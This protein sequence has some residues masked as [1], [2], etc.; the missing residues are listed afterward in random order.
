MNSFSLRSWVEV[1]K[2]VSETEDHII[3]TNSKLNFN[4]LTGFYFNNPLTVS[5]E[6]DSIWNN[7]TM[8][9]D[10]SEIKLIN[11]G[12]EFVIHIIDFDGPILIK[13][14][15][16][17]LDVFLCLRNPPSYFINKEQACFDFN[18]R[19]FN[20][21]LRRN[22]STHARD[23]WNLR[24]ALYNFSLQVSN[25]CHLVERHFDDHSQLEPTNFSP[26]EEF[27][28]DYLLKI[29][30]SK[31]A[32]VLPPKLPNQFISQLNKSSIETVKLLL[33]NTV[34]VRF[35]PLYIRH[36]EDVE[37]PFPDY[38]PPNEY[39][40][41]P[42]VKVTPS[43]I[44]FMSKQ[45]V[46]KNRVYRYFPKSENFLLVSFTDEYDGNP[47]RS[48]IVNK[49]FF[50]I[51]LDGIQVGGKTFTFLGCSNSQLRI[52]RCWFSCLD[53]QTVYDTIGEFPDDWNAG[54]KL[55]RIALAFASSRNTVHLDHDRYLKNVGPDVLQ[56]KINFSDGIGRASPQL[57]SKIQ[58]IIGVK[59]MVSAFQIRVGGIKGVI[60]LYDEQRDDV[61]FRKSMKKFES[62]HNII[63]VLNFS[64]PTKLYLNRHVI[65][66][67]S[68]NG[69]EN[70][71]LLDLQHEELLGCLKALM[72]DDSA[73]AFVK[74]RS[75]IFNWDILPNISR[76]PFFREILM[77]NATELVQRIVEHARI[78]VPN[79]RVLMGVMDETGTLEY[80]EV[81]ANIVDEEFSMEIEGRVL[82]F[83]NPCVL[84]S[85]IRV[86]N[87]CKKSRLKKI[88]QNCLVFPSKGKTS[89]ANECAGGDLDGD[90][91]YVAWDETIV[92]KFAVPGRDAIEV[93]TRNVSNVIGGNTDVDMMQF[94]CDYVSKN[95]LG[96]IANAHLATADKLGMDHLNT[97]ALAKYV[98]AETDAP[99]K[100]F[101][102]GIIDGKLLPDEYPDYMQKL[103]KPSYQSESVLGEMFRQAK[104]LLDVLLEKRKL[105]TPPRPIISTVK[106]TIE[107]NYLQYT[108]E[109]NK[110]L[111]S[112]E[113]VS[114][115]DLF[116][117]TPIWRKGYMSAY[118]QQTQ[119]RLNVNEV[120]KAFWSK[121]QHIFEEW[122]VKICNNQG[123]ISDWFHYPDKD[124]NPVRSFAYLAMPFVNFEETERWSM[125][126]AILN[127]VT[128]WVKS[129]RVYWLDEWRKR[130]H[131][132][133]TVIETL[134]GVKCHFYGSSMLALNED[135]SDVDLYAA[136]K[137]FEKLCNSLKTIDDNVF[138]QKKPHEC[139]SLTVQSLCVDVTNFAGGVVKTYGL[140]ET[141]DG[142]PEI[143]SA[144]KVLLEWA[145][146][147][148]IVKSGGSE[149]FMSVISFCHLFIFFATKAPPR[150]S[151]KPEPYTLARLDKWIDAAKNSSVGKL[152][153]DFFTFISDRKNQSWI[154]EKKDP[155]SEEALIKSDLV[156]ELRKNAEI[157]L[158][159]LAVYDG[160]VQKLFQLCSKK[161]LYRIDKRYMNPVS[162]SIDQRKQCFKEIE[163]KCNPTRSKELKLMLVDRNG[164]FFLE[165]IGDHKLFS[166]VEHGLNLIHKR[167]HSVRIKSLNRTYH[168]KNGTI[169]LPEFGFG[170]AT[171]VSFAPYTSDIYIPIHTGIYKSILIVRNNIRNDKWIHEDAL[172]YQKRFQDQ[173]RLYHQQ[174]SK[175]S[176]K[177]QITWR[178]FGELQCNIRLGNHYM[179]NVP[180]SLS[181]TFETI[182]LKQVEKSISVLEEAFDVENHHAIVQ[183]MKNYN[184][185]TLLKQAVNVE[186]N[187]P[188]EL[189]SLGEMKKRTG[190]QK[191]IKGPVPI[192]QRKKLNGI[193]HSFAPDW[194]HGPTDVARFATLNG[195]KAVS[196]QPND[197][198]IKISVLWRQRELVVSCDNR[199]VIQEIGHR[200]TRWLAATM[201]RADQD[202]GDDIRLYLECRNSLDEDES[203]IETIID[204][205]RGQSVFRDN[206]IRE[207]LE[208][209]EGERLLKKPLISKMMEFNWRFRS[210]RFISPAQK[211]IN[212][213]GDTLIL[214]EVVD[215]VFRAETCEFE[216]FPQHFELELRMNMK[217]RSEE[218]LSKKSYELASSLFN[219]TKTLPKRNN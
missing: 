42:R 29:W 123:K 210:M 41:I 138:S 16:N 192:L 26:L 158:Y 184:R 40:M 96:I 38:D 87:A 68:E 14:E 187:A 144:L 112:F 186:N 81:Y 100:G 207:M 50:D 200:K 25:V 122:R 76:D 114:E 163:M 61:M 6:R 69:I 143:W 172:R 167:I 24:Q 45:A 21:R 125:T 84:P 51:L 73:V 70:E 103:E 33:H 121:W 141:F 22:E 151:E 168:V 176:K 92:P 126:Q 7:F 91:Y 79:G 5:T 83:R 37:L 3:V 71:V 54:R 120:V 136:E 27:D 93:E 23:S 57:M 28:R 53:R 165:A 195:F 164:V 198:Y 154:V 177:G 173:M 36:I 215:G 150:L 153:F 9:I 60:S 19:S 155:F 203:I 185:T 97:I 108:F 118:K 56:G 11:G 44:V 201:K 55:T 4:S 13:E 109:I 30:Q 149:G 162:H 77:S 133:E 47:W 67:L 17:S 170:K 196:F 183:E 99:K 115:T 145:R 1:V 128:L 35:Q 74:S 8:E 199:G 63:E 180:E 62:K 31:H 117:G 190:Q 137:N 148:R 12:K 181:N 160:N 116:S 134:K 171:E 140:A 174:K 127:S 216:W 46:T 182:S 188:L 211:Y 202:V 166:Y 107:N 179:F 132:G 64:R 205:L 82:V 10:S 130:C 219:F 18:K 48:E 104:P 39:A 72:H 161:R 135:Y 52:G 98:A 213:E 34:P 206:F 105:I 59:E 2:P 102:V 90:L 208:K 157:A 193:R 197:S 147:V 32:A 58:S 119:H 178:F 113:L 204:R 152:I 159:Y 191:T 94:F 75:K 101:T 129:N 65:L 43:R 106:D 194:S 217:K 175:R 209:V 78:L 146:N 89:H 66:L 111:M 169:I 131:V 88:Y 189:F 80:G 49:H 214:Q 124:I 86:L 20:L 85:D 95:Q 156:K 15:N 142:N 110:L 218:D 139:V 212:D